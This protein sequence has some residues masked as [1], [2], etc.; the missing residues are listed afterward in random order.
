MLRFPAGKAYITDQMSAA[1]DPLVLLTIVFHCFT[2]PAVLSM[3]L[4]LR[5][6]VSSNPTLSSTFPR[7]PIN[8]ILLFDG[9]MVLPKK[10]AVA[11]A[12]ALG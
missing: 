1:R 5:F 9:L 3:L 8:L 7:L 2:M 11:G 6:R 10:G 12:D 4:K